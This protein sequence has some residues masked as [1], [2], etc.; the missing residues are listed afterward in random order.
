MEGCDSQRAQSIL[1]QS[2]EQLQ[3]DQGSGKA[4]LLGFLCDVFGIFC[5]QESCE[6]GDSCHVCEGI[7]NC[8]ETA[9]PKF[10]QPDGSCSAEF[11]T[12]PGAYDPCEDK[13]CGDTC[14]ICDPADPGC[15]ETDVIKLCNADGMCEAAVPECYDPCEDKTC[16]DTCTICDPAQPDCAET[17]VVKLCNADGMC[18][19]A[20]P[21][22]PEAACCDIADLPGFAGNAFCFEGA[23]CCSDGTWQCNDG[24]GNSTCAADAEMCEPTECGGFLALACPSGDFDCVDNPLDDCDPQNGGADC[25][26]VCIEN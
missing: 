21:E 15:T 22:C 19:A 10:C 9:V 26:G 25:A 2:C 6:C 20:V 7:P 4:D 17:D 11:P 13:T 5:P 8:F 24:A 23:T 12:C 1:D 16:G 18:E 3:A 14:T